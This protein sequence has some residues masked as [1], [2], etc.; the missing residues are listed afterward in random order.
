ME[1]IS[2]EPRPDWQAKV[3]S[4]G[5]FFHTAEGKPY[6][7]EEAYYQFAAAEIEVLESAT[8]ALQEMCLEAVQF[9]I[10]KER[11]ADLAIPPKAIAAIKSSW[12]AE[13]PSVYGRF[14]L[15]YDG[16]T[17]PK[18][19]EY[20]ADTPT[21]LLEA[22]VVQWNWLKERFPEADQFN[23]I[24]ENLISKWGDLK[25][26]G[27]LPMALVH[28]VCEN[29]IEDVMTITALRD[30]AEQAAVLTEAM[31][32]AEVGWDPARQEFV[33]TKGRTMHTVFKLYPWEWLL[34]DDFGDYVIESYAKV[35]WME[36]I[37]KMVL[38]NKGILAILWE[39]YPNHPN[40]L[41]AY[42]GRSRDL[43]EW[44]RKPLLSREGANITVKRKGEIYRTDG[45]YGDEG[46]VYQAL[47]NIPNFNG[48]HP[49][50]GSWVVMD[51]GACGIGIRES[52]TAVTDN[53][54][55]FVPHL[56]R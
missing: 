37:W 16:S 10:D 33:D 3:E 8:N 9:V 21:S 12:D 7:F 6:W 13:P 14:D 26:E 29:N 32:I 4:L 40:L 38:S 35:N 1:R 18:L 39:M 50:I 48:A 22:A 49:V 45:I 47:A 55:R 52:D 17:P 31:Y 51:K 56:I 25:E 46:F 15:A 42:V 11:F 34:N 53:W 24:W 41:P 23:S 19:L 54:S 5:L 28:F 27:C 36:P 43:E 30:T 2:I 20:N 44:V